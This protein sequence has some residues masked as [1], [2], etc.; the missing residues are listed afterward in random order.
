MK[1]CAICGEVLEDSAIVCLKC[2]RGIFESEKIRRSNSEKNIITSFLYPVNR[3]SV[4]T[5]SENE[6]ISIKD[7]VKNVTMVSIAKQCLKRFTLTISGYDNDPRELYEI[8]DVCVWARESFLKIPYLI[9]FLDNASTN[10]FVAWLLGPLSK[11]EAFSKSFESKFTKKLTK[12]MISSGFAA[13][14]YI[15]SL[16][17]DD[18]LFLLFSTQRGGIPKNKWWQLWK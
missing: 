12:V 16:G 13:S 2:G 1:K 9:Y 3:H 4:E 17:G 18:K 14:E 8:H 7:Y 5:C 11:A 10:R 6:I 15:N